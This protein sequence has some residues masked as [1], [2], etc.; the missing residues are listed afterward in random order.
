MIEN[1]IIEYFGMQINRLAVSMVDDQ[2][3][4]VL[5]IFAILQDLLSTEEDDL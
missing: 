4:I 1:N 5:D 2:F 3:Y